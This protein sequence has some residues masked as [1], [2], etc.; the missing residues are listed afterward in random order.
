MV[1]FDWIVKLYVHYVPVTRTNRM[2]MA[3]VAFNGKLRSKTRK[4]FGN[5]TAV[6]NNKTGTETG[7]VKNHNHP[8]DERKKKMGS[9]LV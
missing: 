3:C 7:P 1:R 8:K 2:E 5:V 6:G 9:K 4:G